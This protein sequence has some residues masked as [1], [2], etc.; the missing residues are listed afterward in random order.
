MSDRAETEPRPRVE[1]RLA[2]ILAA[3]VVG[4]SRLMGADEHGTLERLK[5]H[6]R[7]LIEPKLTEHRGRIVKLM[8]DGALVEFA[9]VVDAVRCAAEIQRAMAERNRVVPE[10]QSIAFRIGINLG[11]VIVE[12]DDIYGDGVN[13][14]ARLEGLAEPGGVCISAKVHDEVRDRLELGF[15]DL[16]EQEVK[17]IARP[18]RIYKVVLSPVADQ[19]VAPAQAPRLPDKPSIVVLA[20]ENMSQDPEQEYF[21]DGIA[22]DIITDLSRISGLFVIARNSAFTYKG[23]AANLRDV[24]RELGVRHVLEGSVRKAGNRVRITAQLIDGR[25][26]GHVWAER[27]D[28]ELTDIFEVQDDVTREIVTALKVHLTRDERA[29]VEKRGTENLDAYDCFLRGRQLFWQ[30]SRE[31][32]GQAQALF[33]EA[34]ALD[35][36]FPLAHAYLAFT[37]SVQYVNRWSA[38]PEGSLQR[39][40]ELVDRALTLDPTEAEAHYV[41]GIIH[42]WHQKDPD[43]AIADAER[44]IALDPG[45]A[46]GYGS[47]GAALHYAG[48][49]EEAVERLARMAR[50]DPHHP[51]Q[52][53][54]FLAQ[55]LFA[56]GRFEDAVRASQARL[57]RQPHSDV[58]RVLLAACYGHLGRAEEARAEWEEALRINPDYSIEHRRQILPYKNPADFERVVEGLRKA[59]IA[60]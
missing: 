2:A 50:L 55:S 36:A 30:I 3:D 8:G 34:V 51:A 39:A 48:R 58:S 14:A 11:D 15:E 1:R 12:G 16:G 31:A 21:A 35:A 49:S 13:V 41:Q 45:F 57:A 53:Q 7:E 54:H 24:S 37:H 9:S 40:Q 25:T 43:Q 32:I 23:K 38:D 44:A 29:R 46:R 20:F 52:Y 56:L 10:A 4:Y 47:L 59:G 18:V 26:G 42:L 27:Y 6:R 22:E 33:E 60:V 19:P 5:R 28:R 17:N